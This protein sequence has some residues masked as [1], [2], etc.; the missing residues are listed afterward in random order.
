M[1]GSWQVAVICA[2]LG[3]PQAHQANDL[4]SGKLRKKADKC[5]ARLC[6]SFIKNI[7]TFEI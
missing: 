4:Y 3:E 2:D 1:D 7:I 6:S 5:S